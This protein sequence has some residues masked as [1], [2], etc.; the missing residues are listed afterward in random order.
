MEIQSFDLSRS[1]KTHINAAMLARIRNPSLIAIEPIG[2]LDFV[3]FYENSS[4]GAM[5]SDNINLVR[6]DNYVR[7]FGMG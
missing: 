7:M 4:V 3:I 1:N 5:L 6:G 2:R